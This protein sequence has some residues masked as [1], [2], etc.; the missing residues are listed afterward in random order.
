VEQDLTNPSLLETSF[1]YLSQFDYP[2]YTFGFIRAL[3]QGQSEFTQPATRQQIDSVETSN[4]KIRVFFL[5]EFPKL[6]K[7]ESPPF[8][9]RLQFIRN[10]FRIVSGVVIISATN[11]AA[12]N[13]VKMGEFSRFDVNSSSVWCYVFPSLPRFV[14]TTDRLA[15]LTGLPIVVKKII[16]SSRPLFAQRALSYLDSHRDCN[17]ENLV[18]YLERMAGCLAQD[19]ETWK[20]YSSWFFDG[21]VCLFLC[22]SFEV[23]QNSNLIDGHFARLEETE[24]FALEI[25]DEKPIKN[26]T[27][28]DCFCRFPSPE[29][30][31]LLYLT[32]TGGKTYA[33][34]RSSNRVLLFCEALEKALRNGIKFKLKNTSQETNDGM[35]F[36]AL[37]CGSIVLASHQ[38]GFRGASFCSFFVTLLE[39]LGMGSQNVTK[40]ELTNALPDIP[41]TIPFLCPPNVKWPE[42][43]LADPRMYFGF[44]ERP[45]N[46][47]M[48]DLWVRN[49]TTSLMSGECKNYAS[50]LGLGVLKEIL[51]RVPDSTT[52]HLV[53]VNK[54]QE[55]YFAVLGPNSQTFDQFV[56]RPVLPKGKILQPQRQLYHAQFYRIGKGQNTLQEIVGLE[57]KCR[58]P[59][60]PSSPV[61]NQVARTVIFMEVQS[62]ASCKERFRCVEAMEIE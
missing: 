44:L 52:V 6:D 36:E 45:P 55:K 61:C 1:A 10:V 28:W 26:K 38:N 20:S 41:L 34:L 40:E 3:L 54:L 24:G 23:N 35:K 62:R 57:N 37:V 50:S 31:L 53:A 46:E 29:D 39:E 60:C 4:D 7:G 22:T 11:G 18:E 16:T 58:N 43:L 42:F 48:V 17:E 13:L 33:P 9:R 56:A 59:A 49:Q 27:R 21:Q 5:D 47:D 14:D 12:R 2:L 30:D 15:S 25:V 8:V 32:L 51:V 19:F